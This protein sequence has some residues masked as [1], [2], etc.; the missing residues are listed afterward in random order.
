MCPAHRRKVIAKLKLKL[1][2]KTRKCV[3]VST[4]LIE[5]GIDID[6]EAA[7]RFLAGFDSIIQTAGRCNR[8]GSLKDARGNYI[9]G[10]TYIINVVKDEENIDSLKDLVLGQKVMRRILDEYHDDEA[11]YDY[12]LLHPDLIEQYFSY[13]YGQMPDSL[14]KYK[15]FAE[16]N[17]RRDDTLIDLLSSNTESVQEYLVFNEGKSGRLTQF[18]QSFESAWGAFEAIAQDTVGVIVPFKQGRNIIGE[19]NGLP[20]IKRCAVL[21]GKAQRYSVNLYRKGLEEL[22]EAGI[23]RRIP[24]NNQMEIYELCERYYDRHI[25]LTREPGEMTLLNV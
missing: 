15:V 9:T 16:Y 22:R 14:L 21:L 1:R 12:T 24:A 20:D 19:L 8:N 11:A 23:V 2:D 4:R 18:R 5:A 13:Y 6:F 3:C 25:G 10:K 17:G 7:I